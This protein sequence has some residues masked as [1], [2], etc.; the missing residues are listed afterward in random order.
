[1]DPDDQRLWDDL[2]VEEYLRSELEF[3]TTF[4]KSISPQDPDWDPKMIVTVYTPPGRFLAGIYGAI[5]DLEEQISPGLREKARDK[6]TSPTLLDQLEEEDFSLDDPNDSVYQERWTPTALYRWIYLSLKFNF[7]EMAEDEQRDQLA[8]RIYRAQFYEAILLDSDYGYEYPL[9]ERDPSISVATPSSQEETDDSRD[10]V[11]QVPPELLSEILTLAHDGVLYFPVIISQVDSRFRAIA[12]STPTLWTTIDIN[13]PLPF[14]MMYLQNSKNSLLDVRMNV[15]HAVRRGQ[16]MPRLRTIMDL[17]ADQRPRIASLFI[18]GRNPAVVDEITKTMLSE[19]SSYHQLTKLDTGCNLWIGKGG[20]RRLADPLRYPVVPSLQLQQ[21]LLR[22]YRTRDWTRGIVTPMSEL[23]RLHLADNFDLVLS[24][25]LAVLP[26]LPSLNELIID[27]CEISFA[28]A[29]SQIV[30]SA[31]L[32]K[33]TILECL[34]L[35]NNSMNSILR[36]LVTPNLTS[37][38]LWWDFGGKDWINQVD[39]VVAIFQASPRLQTL[40][41]CN[42]EALVPLWKDV[43]GR[44]TSVRTLRLRSCELV[45]EDLAG[46]W[47]PHIEAAPM[48]PH[49]EHLA[50]ENVLD[51]N[52]DVVRRIVACRPGLRRVELRGW[53]DGRVDEADV[54]F[55]RGSVENFVLETFGRVPRVSDGETT[56]SGAE[57]WS[58]SG[59]PSEGSWVSGDEEIVIR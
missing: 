31:T 3:I 28:P 2:S 55:I 52:T 12:E 13:L 50:I 36:S 43:F 39:G 1:M 33:L 5:A 56:D 20:I 42:F 21:L 8:F 57:E 32:P 22:G 7:V 30:T 27:A 54:R 38:K 40:D 11:H 34:R 47:E 45:E 10:F 51:L 19:G 59:T 9:D 35:N 41:L 44:A 4:A 49:L 48:T 18:Q 26:N 23:N 15:S 14:I 24:E 6:E 17:L 29:S 58:S 16:T 37:T 25:L 46:L 53:Y